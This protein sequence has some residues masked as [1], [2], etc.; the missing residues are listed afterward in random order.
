MN[1][2]RVSGWG[3]VWALFFVWMIGALMGMVLFNFGARVRDVSAATVEWALSACE[4]NGGLGSMDSDTAVCNNGAMFLG[5][6]VSSGDT[7]R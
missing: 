1:D 5:P 7:E 2:D 6:P 4:P 3:V